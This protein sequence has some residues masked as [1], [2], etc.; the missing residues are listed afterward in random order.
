[1]SN[2][3]AQD[4]SAT[5]ALYDVD[6][7]GLSLSDSHEES[8]LDRDTTATRPGT[9]SYPHFRQFNRR[10]SILPMLDERIDRSTANERI[11]ELRSAYDALLSKHNEVV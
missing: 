3:T 5:T 10:E 8:A 7:A 11:T 9:S 6:V 4:L 1:M 2:S